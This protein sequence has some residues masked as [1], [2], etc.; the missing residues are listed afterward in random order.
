VVDKPKRALNL[1][2]YDEKKKIIY[3]PVV[4]DNGK[5]ISVDNIPIQ[6]KYYDFQWKE[7]GAVR[8]IESSFNSGE[9]DGGEYDWTYIKIEDGGSEV[10]FFNKQKQ[11]VGKIT[12]TS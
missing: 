1:I 12:Y 2:T 6:P 9:L 11:E 4:D 5:V 10:V 3:I 8:S 7:T